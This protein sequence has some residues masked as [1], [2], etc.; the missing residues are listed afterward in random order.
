[1]GLRPV[2]GRHDRAGRRSDLD[3]WTHQGDPARRRRLRARGPQ[4]RRPGQGVHRRREPGARHLRPAAVRQRGSA[5]QAG[6]DRDVGQGAD[7]AV[8]RP[9]LLADAP[10]GT[11]SGGNQQKVIVAR[12][13]SRPLKL[14]IAAQPTRGVDV[15]SIE[16]IHGR[17]IHER[18]VGTAVLLVSSELDEVIG[19]GRPDRGHV[20]RPDHRHRRPGHPARGDRPADGGHHRTDWRRAAPRR[21]PATEPDDGMRPDEPD[22]RPGHRG[23]RRAA[24]DAGADRPPAGADGPEPARSLGSTFLHNLWTANTFT[25]TL[26]AMVLA[27][28]IGAHPDHHLRPRRAGHLHAT[29]PPARPT[30]STRAGTWSARRTPTCSRARSST[31]RR[32]AAGSTAPAAGSRSSSRSRRR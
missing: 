7:R 1:M 22:A 28:V 27:M 31:R 19:A 15:G 14:F 11:L 8:R 17:I 23:R 29:S 20:P 32:S 18:D 6:R 4:R 9:H 3:G 25:V 26:L 12:E 16:F 2:A 30:R 13:M 21:P 10:V 5:L 24:G